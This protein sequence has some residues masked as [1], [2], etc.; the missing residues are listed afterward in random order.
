MS[1]LQALDHVELPE[2]LRPVERPGK[3]PLD[4]LGQLHPAP[5]V[6]ERR[7]T[8]VE[9]QVERGVIDPD[10]QGWSPNGTILTFC[11]RRG[12]RCRREANTDTTSSN[13]S[14]PV[15]PGRRI[16]HGQPGDVHVH[17]RSLQ[18]AG[19]TRRERGEAFGGHDPNLPLHDRRATGAQPRPRCADACAPSPC[20][21]SPSC[22]PSPRHRRA[23]RAVWQYREV[24]MID[25]V[26]SPRVVRVPV[27][28]TARV[29]ERR[30]RP[31]TT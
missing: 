31:R 13:C 21:H 19:T 27:G 6:R 9:V 24:E 1:V 14:P 2:R 22:S 28:G 25:N 4:L 20:S 12:A 18:A 17:R 11:R 8:D 5:R 30:S 16:E 15:G 3:D 10:R 23:R 7:A 26:F 29:D